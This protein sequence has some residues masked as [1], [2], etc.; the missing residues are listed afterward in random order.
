MPA[1]TF[2][3]SRP[4]SLVAAELLDPD[5]PL[6]KWYC[7]RPECDG[8]P[9]GKWH[10]CEH[11]LPHPVGDEYWQ[12]RH[13][14]AAQ[15]PPP[16][17]W[18]VWLVLAGRGFGKTRTGA[19]WLAREAM[20]Q[21]GTS[22]AVVAPTGK[23]LAEVCFEGDSGLLRALGMTRGD[24]A[25][26]KSA[27]LLRLPNGSVIRSLSAE[28]PAR[29]RGPNLA[30]A[31]LDELAIYP[32]RETWDDLLPA[33]RRASARVVVT[34]TPRPVPLITEWTKRTDGSVVVTRG[35]MFDNA[36]NLSQSA[37][38]DVRMRWE[39]T[40]M[41]DQELYGMLLEDVPGALWR[42]ESI[43]ANRLMLEDD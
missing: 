41:A 10:F 31:W 36:A 1:V 16:G 37:L 24:E 39:G 21:P 43:E 29:S 40:R 5:G 15:C 3:S 8:E 30:G 26:N 6:S 38:D 9:H 28:R 14:R 4:A 25:Y 19:E 17:S 42:A 13:A 35:S 11:P 2:A 18:R 27:L 22:W 23:D 33:L 12:C 32:Y 20:R 7:D 34:T